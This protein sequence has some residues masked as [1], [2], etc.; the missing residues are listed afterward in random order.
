MMESR[1]A[2]VYYFGT[3]AL[4]WTAIVCSNMNWE[5]GSMWPPTADLIDDE[6]VKDGFF[7]FIL[8]IDFQAYN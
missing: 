5:N 4:T 2:A 3:H 7:T 8:S 1:S 6:S